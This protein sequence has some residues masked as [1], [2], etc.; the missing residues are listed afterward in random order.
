MSK[1][2]AL[3]P[4]ANV[5]IFRNGHDLVELMLVPERGPFVVRSLDAGAYV[6][7]D[8]CG[9]R[10]EF[11]VLTDSL[12]TTV[13]EPREGRGERVGGSEPGAASV[14]TIDAERDTRP[15]H[16]L[17]TP[18]FP[19]VGRDVPEPDPVSGDRAGD[20]PAA[21]RRQKPDYDVGELSRAP[22]APGAAIVTEAPEEPPYDPQAV[23][24]DRQIEEIREREREEEVA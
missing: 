17:N 20:E 10:I 9:G 1:Q 12:Q 15:W 3:T 19:N 24:T 6:A 4:G 23:N 7:V 16:P 5:R 2:K 11:E 14:Q 21:P 18:A 22:G 13:W 8:D